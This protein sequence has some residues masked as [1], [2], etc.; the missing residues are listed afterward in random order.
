[1]QSLLVERVKF[2]FDIHA[3]DPFV[4]KS[5]MYWPFRTLRLALSFLNSIQFTLEAHAS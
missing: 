4:I 1:M 2:N 5:G 3:T